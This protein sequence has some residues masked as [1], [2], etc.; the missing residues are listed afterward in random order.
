[1]KL[2]LKRKYSEYN[3]EDDLNIYSSD[4]RELL[5]EDDA[6]SPMEEAF[7]NGYESAA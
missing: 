5:L 6:L 4:V 1:M 3:D 2:R 7:M